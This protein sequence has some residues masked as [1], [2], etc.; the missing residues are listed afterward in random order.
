MLGKQEAKRSTGY[1]VSIC[2]NVQWVHAN[3][4]QNTLPTQSKIQC[5]L[6]QPKINL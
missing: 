3:T 6:E 1:E 2:L 4:I 5:L